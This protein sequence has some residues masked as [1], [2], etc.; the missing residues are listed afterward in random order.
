MLERGIRSGR[1]RPIGLLGQG[2]PGGCA[3]RA[4]APHDFKPTKHTAKFANQLGI[5]IQCAINSTDVSFF[6]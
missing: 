2:W 5:G 4:D 1:Q 3:G 6:I